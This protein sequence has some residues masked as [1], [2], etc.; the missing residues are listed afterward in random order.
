MD[1]CENELF[2]FLHLHIN[3]DMDAGV[4]VDIYSPLS[5]TLPSRIFKQGLNESYNKFS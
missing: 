3:S 2:F 4:V 1:Q 5:T